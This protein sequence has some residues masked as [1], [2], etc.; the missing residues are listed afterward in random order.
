MPDPVLIDPQLFNRR[1]PTYDGLKA[2]WD[3]V[4]QTYH[5]GRQWFVNNVFKYMREGTEEYEERVK[6]SYR[7]NHSREV[8]DMVT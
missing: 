1:H 2:H 4:E 8:V 7:F 3:F 6:R 5:G